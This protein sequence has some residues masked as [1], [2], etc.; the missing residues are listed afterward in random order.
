M[1][2][3]MHLFNEDL[4]GNS[5]GFWSLNYLLAALGQ[6]SSLQVPRRTREVL[7]TDIIGSLLNLTQEPNRRHVMWR[8]TNSNITVVPWAAPTLSCSFFLWYVTKHSQAKQCNQQH[9][10]TLWIC[11]NPQNTEFCVVS[12]RYPEALVFLH[13]VLREIYSAWFPRVLVTYSRPTVTNGHSGCV[14]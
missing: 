12:A 5:H 1:V 3:S 9:D 6:L 8:V 4:S 14:L 13:W 11:F 2:E 7:T 10:S